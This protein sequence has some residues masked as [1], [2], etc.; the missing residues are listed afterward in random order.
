MD[1]LNNKLDN[2][3]KQFKNIKKIE[4]DLGI[5]VSGEET[6]RLIDVKIEE[7]SSR[8]DCFRQ[9][10]DNVKRNDFVEETSH[11]NFSSISKRNIS[12]ATINNKHER[13]Q[14]S[15]EEANEIHKWYELLSKYSAGDATSLSATNKNIIIHSV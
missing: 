6:T 15:M 1:W 11:H 13:P 7:S 5:Q 12:S 9:A 4:E 10:S 8:Y 3:T 14:H 2:L